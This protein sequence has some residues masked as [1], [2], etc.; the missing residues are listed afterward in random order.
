MNKYKELVLL[1]DEAGVKF[2]ATLPTGVAHPGD[3]VPIDGSFLTVEE[4]EWID[5]T[6]PIYQMIQQTCD[7]VS[8]EQILR[9]KWEKEENHAD[10]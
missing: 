10:A 9:V 5:V 6:S 3:L 7:I 8:V 2:L 4:A 1:T